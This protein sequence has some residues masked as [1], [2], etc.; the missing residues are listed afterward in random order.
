MLQHWLFTNHELMQMNFPV[1]S[2]IFLWLLLL[3][4]CIEAQ[5]WQN[6][7]SP[8]ITLYSDLNNKLSSFRLDSTEAV[9]G[10]RL[11]SVYKSYLTLRKFSANQYCYDT[12]FGFVLGEK[13]YRKAT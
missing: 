10:N 13:V 12:V 7:C 2:L 8:G 4:V 1:K 9:P 3:P 6:I 5:N 11:D